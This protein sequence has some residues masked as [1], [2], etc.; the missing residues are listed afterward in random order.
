V[1]SLFCQTLV[2]QN[3]NLWRRLFMAIAA[4]L[5][6]VLAMAAVGA[7]LPGAAS[8]KDRVVRV[9][10]TETEPQTIQAVNDI[11]RRFEA[12]SPGIKI[13]AEGL[14][15]AELEGKI[16]ASLASGDPP[17]LSHGQPI[18]CTALQSKGLLSPL[19]DVVKAIGEANIW[20][21]V[22]RVCNID[23]KQYGLVHAAGTSLLIYRKDL[24]DK[25]GLKPPKTWADLLVNVKALTQDTNDDGKIDI[26]GI[27]IPGDNLFINIILGELIKANGGVL[28]DKS[29]R[30]QLTDRRMIEVLELW[31]ELAKYAPPGWQGHG[32]LQTFQN[33]YGQKAAMMFQ[34]YGRGA[35]MIEKFAPKEMANDKTFDVWIKPHGP[36]GAEP[37]VQVDE[38]PW[39]LFKDSKNQKEA[40]E[41]LKYFYRDDNYLGY[42]ATVPIHLFPITKS[43]RNSPKYQNLEMIQRWKGWIDVQQGYLDR[44]QGKPTLVVDWIDMTEKP[45]LMEVLGSGILRDMVMDVAVE[46]MEPQEAAERAQKRLEGL[47]RNKGYL[48]S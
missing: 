26:Y 4:R 2:S 38:E 36:S 21:Q 15:W 12:K 39:M 3:K 16:M 32:Y 10:H 11:A 25:L 14:G 29:N 13:Q 7:L 17:E 19:D 27:S 23:G 22:K 43:L 1:A 46:K 44:D 30:P 6:R 37:A 20:E 42:V 28:F 41:F 45:F 31:R 24:A 33:I 40:I 35:G 9:W 34:G 8:A 5:G 18:T 47:L 48:K